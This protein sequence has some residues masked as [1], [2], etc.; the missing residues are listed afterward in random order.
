M[1]NLILACIATFLFVL[2]IAIALGI[3]GVPTSLSDTFY[4]YNGI[5]KN[6]G[7][8]FTAMMFF[9]PLLLMPAWLGITEVITPWSQYLLAL[10]FFGASS[11]CFVGA[12]PAFKGISME[13]K[14]HTIAAIFSAVCSLLWVAIVCWKI[15]WIIPLWV[16]IIGGLAHLTKTQKS[17]KTFWLEMIAFGATF[18]SIIIEAALLL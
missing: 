3:F 15:M 7:Y 5:K 17:G 8:I 2:Y 16:L 12:A 11:I 1:I 18:S 10:P 4:L 9:V 13:G 6:L 14:V